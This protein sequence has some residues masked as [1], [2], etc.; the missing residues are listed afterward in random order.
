[1]YQNM[2]DFSQTYICRYNLYELT[3]TVYVLVE[4]ELYVDMYQNMN[5][6]A[7]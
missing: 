6:F 5:E 2:N 1:M 7:K 3:P 4:N